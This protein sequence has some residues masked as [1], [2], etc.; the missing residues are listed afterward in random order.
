MLTILCGSV[1]YTSSH[2]DEIQD[3]LRKFT[4][5]ATAEFTGYIDSLNLPLTLANGEKVVVLE[6]FATS[7]D[8]ESYDF[9]PRG[10]KP[11]PVRT[12]VRCSLHPLPGPVAH[13]LIPQ[14]PKSKPATKVSSGLSLR[15]DLLMPTG[16]SSAATIQA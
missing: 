3:L 5:G 7:L 13:I 4:V 10:T 12:K 15:Y 16:S 8:G 9:T 2:Y 11:L 1:T 14:A 6:L